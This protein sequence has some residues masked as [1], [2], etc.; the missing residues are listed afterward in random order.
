MDG[1]S[2]AADSQAAFAN[3]PNGG[4]ADPKEAL[5]QKNRRMMAAQALMGMAG[6][7]YRS[8]PTQGAMPM[9]QQRPLPAA[10]PNA[11]QWIGGGR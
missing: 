8:A 11:G 3:M 1:Y 7:S 9:P 6:Q 4:L 2:Q 10:V 5:A